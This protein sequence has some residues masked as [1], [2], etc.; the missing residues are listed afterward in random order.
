MADLSI[1]NSHSGV[2]CGVDEAGRGPLVGPVV[3]AAV[4]LD[5]DNIPEGINDSKKL[6]LKKREKLFTEINLTA[7]VAVGIASIEEIDSINIL[8]ASMLAMQ[9]AVCSLGVTPDMALID[10]NRTPKELPCDAI[11]VIKGD[12]KSLSIAAASI[13]AKV[14]RDNLICELA[15]EFPA[16]GWE[17]NSGYGTKEHKD[18]MTKHGITKY[19]RKSFAPV[20]Q[21]LQSS[22]A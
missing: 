19:H 20:K 18:A 12:S 15:K 11:A 17:R 3:A 14:T 13:I 9:R 8:W 4:I 2:I 10:G 21:F 6:S 7:K 22:C 1:E 16:Y 5:M